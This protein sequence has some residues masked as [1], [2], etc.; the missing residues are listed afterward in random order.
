MENKAM[1]KR[2]LDVAYED[3][4]LA[5][6]LGARWD[7]ALKRWYYAKGSPLAKVFGWRAAG[8]DTITSMARENSDIKTPQVSSA[9]QTSFGDLFDQSATRYG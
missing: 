8:A 1:T 5:K 9:A 3:R 6:R 7:P 4:D 2:F